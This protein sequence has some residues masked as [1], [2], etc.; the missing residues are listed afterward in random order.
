M[1]FAG[2]VESLVHISSRELL[3]ASQPWVYVSGIKVSSPG[4][5]IGILVQSPFHIA[6][7]SRLKVQVSVEMTDTSPLLNPFHKRSTSLGFLSCGQQA[8]RCPS[9]RSNTESSRTRYCTHV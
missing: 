7:C 2:L 8:Y 4:N 1:I 6:F 5:P 9:S 3:P